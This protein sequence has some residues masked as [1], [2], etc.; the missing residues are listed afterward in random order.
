MDLMIIIKN[1]LFKPRSE[2]LSHV[3]TIGKWKFDSDDLKSFGEKGQ[4]PM[5][6]ME[7][8]LWGIITS[9]GIIVG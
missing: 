6:L 4:L 3:P 1:F 8:L 2:F 7:V 9:C 5:A